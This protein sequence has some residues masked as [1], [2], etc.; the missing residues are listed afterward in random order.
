ML[1]N[2]ISKEAFMSIFVSPDLHEKLFPRNRVLPVD[3]P[4]SIA[5]EKMSEREITVDEIPIISEVVNLGRNSHK[6]YAKI[7]PMML[8]T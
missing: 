7:I 6:I 2:A 1:V 5:V 3:I 8:S 4:K